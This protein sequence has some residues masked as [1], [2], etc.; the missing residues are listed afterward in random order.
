MAIDFLNFTDKNGAPIKL[1]DIVEVTKGKHKNAEM[2]FLFCVPQHRF[3]FAY[4][5]RYD[6]MVETNTVNGFGFNMFPE[7]FVTMDADLSMYYTPARR[8]E[9]QLKK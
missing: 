2:I 9:V 6:N 5:K 7:E 8:L 1:G 4:K 3:G